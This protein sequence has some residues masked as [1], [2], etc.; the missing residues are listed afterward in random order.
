MAIYEFTSDTIH[1]LSKSTFSELKMGERNDIQRLLRERIEV[2]SPDTLVIAEEFCD[3]DSSRRRIDLLGIDKNANIVVIELKRTEDGG[4]MDLQAIRYAAMV[5]NMQFGQAVKVFAHYLGQ[6][7]D[8]ETDAETELLSHL[9]WEVQD[10][11]KFAQEVKIV[12]ASAEFGQELTTSVLWLNERGIDIRC[13]RLEPYA[14][15]GRTF[16]DIQQIIPLPEASDYQ[17]KVI[18]KKRKEREARASGRDFTKY[19]VTLG[20][21]TIERLAKRH[22]IHQIFAFLVGQGISPEAIA[23]QCGR[24]STTALFAVDGCVDVDE[25]CKLATEERAVLGKTFE[26]GRFLCK[27]DELVQH[28]GKT[29]AFSSQWGGEG[30][31]GA[32]NQLCDKFGSSGVSYAPHGAKFTA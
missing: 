14:F 24:R 25:F 26:P 22:A 4:F 12:L 21:K 32:M 31:E 6:I 7:G 13:V 17:V 15:D 1:A 20:P 29:Y 9:E 28:E 30:W 23:D 10:E 18:D 8:K 19:D 27:A 3:W 2:I 5:A 11:D 16:V